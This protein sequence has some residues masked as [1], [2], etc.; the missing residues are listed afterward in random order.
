[1]LRIVRLMDSLINLS[2]SSVLS[3]EFMAKL[4]IIS[5]I[6]CRIEVVKPQKDSHYTV[7]GAQSTIDFLCG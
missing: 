4:S 5:K 3:V 2:I 7:N 6:R 1:M